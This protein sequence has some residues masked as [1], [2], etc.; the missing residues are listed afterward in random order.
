[1]ISRTEVPS[2]KSSRWDGPH[3]LKW[4]ELQSQRPSLTALLQCEKALIMGLFLYLKIGDHGL[5]LKVSQSVLVGL[6]GWL[7][8]VA[9]LLGDPVSVP[10]THLVAHNHL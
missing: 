9:A 7:S 2:H 4:C 10:S 8:S 3:P 5:C 6:E 1:M